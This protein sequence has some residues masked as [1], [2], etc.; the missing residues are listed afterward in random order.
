MS[1]DSAKVQVALSDGT[2]V[3]DGNR[4]QVNAN[5]QLSGSGVSS[6]TPVPVSMQIG[7]TQIAS[8]YPVPVAIQIGST[9]IA[10]TNPVPVKEQGSSSRFFTSVTTGSTAFT[11]ER[12]FGFTSRSV[13]VTNDDSGTN[14]DFS[15]DG[16][17]VHLTLLPYESITMDGK[18]ETHIYA[19]SN[20]AGKS[21][22]V[23]AW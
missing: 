18:A 9:N 11:T 6:T 1:V 19:R 22:R 20:A 17:N 23:V 2:L 3:T 7:N 12:A 4:F 15:F 16:T 21:F 13:V 10:T 8:T 5:L 14:I